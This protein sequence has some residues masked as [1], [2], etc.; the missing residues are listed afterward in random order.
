MHEEDAIEADGVRGLVV[1]PDGR[2]D[3]SSVKASLVMILT[4]NMRVMER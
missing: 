2:N 4:S 3:V 1:R